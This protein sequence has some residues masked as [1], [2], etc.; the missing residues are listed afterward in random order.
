[1]HLFFDELIIAMQERYNLE[2]SIQGYTSLRAS[3]EYNKLLS[4]RRINSVL[5]DMLNY[6]SGALK[7]YI[8]TKQLVL[9]ELPLGEGQAPNH[10]SDDLDDERNSIYSVGASSQRKVN[11]TVV[12]LLN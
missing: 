12:H 4:H 5:L 11:F 7:P 3:V 8:D 6:K 1:M 9:L 10:V 2:V